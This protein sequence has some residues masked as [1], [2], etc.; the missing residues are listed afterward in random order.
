MCGYCLTGHHERC[1]RDTWATRS[2][3][4]PWTCKCTCG[5]KTVGA[6]ADVS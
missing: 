3:G 4:V 6:D 5:A 1:T 2:G